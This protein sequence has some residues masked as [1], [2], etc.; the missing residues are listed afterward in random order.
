M[1]RWSKWTDIEEYANYKG[2]GVYKIRLVNSKGFPIGISRFLG[3]D[4]DGIL[5]IGESINIERRMNNFYGAIKGKGYAHS[6]AERLYLIKEYT[7]F[8]ERHDSC[9]L[10]YSFTELTSKSQAE[11]EEERLLKC[12][13]K[14]YGEVPPLNAN[15]PQ[16]HVGWQ[17][18][19][20][21]P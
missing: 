21:H 19:K 4:E 16:K 2:C 13:F 8:K 12:Y 11:W 5:V 3:Q 7:N 6:E 10:Q 15:L 18:L 20:C 1:P 9:K 14:R 17:S